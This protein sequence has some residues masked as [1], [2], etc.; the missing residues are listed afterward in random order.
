MA[1]VNM[2]YM[3]MSC[4]QQF[5][6]D[7][8]HQPHPMKEQKHQRQVPM[9]QAPEVSMF[10]P[11]GN[12]QNM[13]D[14]MQPPMDLNCW[15]ANGVMTMPVNTGN[16]SIVNAAV[17]PC[18]GG[19]AIPVISYNGG[20]AIAALAY[21]GNEGSK[22]SNSCS[23]AVTSNESL[24]SLDMPLTD[25]Q[26]PDGSDG[27]TIQEIDMAIR[28]HRMMNRKPGMSPAS[29]GSCSTGRPSDSSRQLSAVSSSSGGTNNGSRF[30]NMNQ[31]QGGNG[32]H[33]WRELTSAMAIA[34]ALG[35]DGDETPPGVQQGQMLLQQLQG[36]LEPE[37]GAFQG[38]A[39][40]DGRFY[41]HAA[42]PDTGST[43]EGHGHG[44]VPEQLSAIMTRFGRQQLPQEF[45]DQPRQWNHNG[46]GAGMPKVHEK[47]RKPRAS[48]PMS[49]A[50]GVVT[51]MIRQ[52]PRQY[53]QLML[54]KEVNRLGFEGLYDFFYLP[55]DLKK[56]INVG[57]GFVS[58]IHPR[59]A[60]AFREEFEGCYLDPSDA[61][62]K[63]LHVHPASVQGYEA[64]CSHFMSTK[65]GQKQDPQFSP[66]FFPHGKPLDEQSA[67]QLGG[68]YVAAHKAASVSR[69]DRASNLQRKAQLSIYCSACD[70][71]L[72]ADQIFCA[73]C[74]SAA[75][76]H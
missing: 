24:K 53:S 2:A 25:L 15:N 26:T 14:L 12:M 36:G 73:F 61:K 3:D 34:K 76:D 65:T 47:P 21:T 10:Q 49:W 56:G 1:G 57:Y 71:V 33:Q 22:N 31:D 52:V 63:P 51:V 60:L 66:L 4:M 68:G 58:F 42:C 23:G 29:G 50:D 20:Y 72:T 45:S 41:G 62:C 38:A 75:P 64:N 46:R 32:Q 43:P 48:D 44:C 6:R 8:Q 19:F 39:S 7:W 18:N 13:P 27:D 40:R 16:D 54:L 37:M 11:F 17:V 5:P 59:H 55:F 70:A 9:Q 67:G 69:A 28:K 30:I 35:R 74:G